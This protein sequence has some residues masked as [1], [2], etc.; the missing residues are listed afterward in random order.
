MS[1]KTGNRENI[2]RRLLE[3]K[4]QLESE[5]Q[6][7]SEMQGELKGIMNQLAEEFGVK[8]LEA[9]EAQIAQKEQ[10]IVQMEQDLR[11]RINEIERLM[12]GDDDD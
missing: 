3:M 5:R 4:K 12:E 9:A 7:R 11:E 1:S 6:Q 2:G 10:D 8:S